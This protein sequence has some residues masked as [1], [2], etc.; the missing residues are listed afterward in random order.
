MTP[1]RGKT[2]AR[3]GPGVPWLA[4]GGIV[5]V[6][7]VVAA[8][9]LGTGAFGFG[10]AAAAVGRVRPST[11]DR[12]RCAGSAVTVD[13]CPTKQPDPLP[14]GQT[15]TV[16][17]NTEKGTIVIKVQ[18]D[19]S[20]IAA[21]NFVTLAA[22]GFYDGTPFHRTAKLQDGTPFVIQGG[23]PKG[24]GSGGP[25]YSDQGRARHDALQARNRRDGSDSGCPTR[26]ARSTSSSSTTRTPTSCPLPTPIR[27]SAT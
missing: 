11:A 12:G 17:L 16:S 19:L 20:P 27:S 10:A 21:G 24:T 26:S 3:S 1:V 14:A 23:D 25:G 4:A 5:V 15:R 6:V 13:N 22:C 8:L 9:I 18:A 2:T 7:L